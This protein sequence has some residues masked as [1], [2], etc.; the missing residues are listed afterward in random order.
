MHLPLETC[1]LFAEAPLFSE[2]SSLSSHWSGYFYSFVASAAKFFSLRSCSTA[3]SSL[4]AAIPLAPGITLLLLRVAVPV[5][6]SQL[7]ANPHSRSDAPNFAQRQQCGQDHANPLL[8]RLPHFFFDFCVKSSSRYSLVSCAFC[9]PDL[10]KVLRTWQFFAFFLCINESMQQWLSESMKQRI[11]EPTDEGMYGWIHG[12]MGELL[13]F[14]GLLL[15]K[16]SRCSLV[17]I[18]RSWS[19]TSAFK[20]LNLNRALAGNRDPTSA[21]PGATLPK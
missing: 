12:W 9:Q 7:V 16:S 6:L 10:P 2:T 1:D 14:V 4:P 19:S 17:H 5:V 13:F 20:D 15:H 11:R 3:F 8:L 21:T 18:L